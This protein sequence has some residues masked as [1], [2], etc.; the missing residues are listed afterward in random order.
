[1]AV[2]NPI[3]TINDI[4]R[5]RQIVAVLF[6]HG[7]GQIVNQIISADTPIAN[8]ISRFRKEDKI[9]EETGL[10]ESNITLA[11]RILYVLQELGPTFIK[12][13]QILST[14]ADL[15]PDEFIQE[16]KNLQDNVPS[17]SF[18]EARLIIE[19]ELSG[20]IE[21]IFESFDQRQIATASIGQVYTAVLRTGEDVVVKV[22]RPNV[23]FVIQRDIDLLYI[24]ARLAERQSEDLKLLDPVGIV[25][26]FE[27]AIQR[28]LD[29]NTE[30]R[31]ALRFKEAFKYHD[32]IE[33]PKV[34]KQYSAKKVLTM[35]KIKGVKITNAENIGCDKKILAKVALSAILHM[36]FENGFFHADP[37]PGNLF[38]LPGNKIGI[39]DLGMVGHLDN[40]MRDKL[41][42]LII[43]LNTRDTDGVAK[44]LYAIGKTEKRIDFDDF[45]KDVDE[46]LNKIL[47]LPL[48]EI[49]FSE[50]LNDLL[51]G[52]KKNRIKIPND[53][54]LMGKAIITIEG[55]GRV[56]DP[57]LNLEEE[58]AP[59]V[60]KLIQDRWTAKRLGLD[61]YKKSKEIYELSNTIPN[62]IVNILDDI[63][64]NNLKLNIENSKQ[65]EMLKIWEQIIGKLAAG[66]ITSALIISSTVFIVSTK[67][68]I[69]FR[70]LPLS[71]LLGIT[72]LI[73]AV[74]LGLNIIRN[75]KFKKPD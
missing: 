5:F 75:I 16:F 28:E 27:K 24:L 73:L 56:L 51:Q 18:E 74:I 52:A 39:L 41:A 72:Y 68:S 40:Q 62:Q 15:V 10:V 58:A 29:Y 63:Q 47:G 69:T 48:S 33:I 46:S 13:G 36:V 37:H 8:L 3:N 60:R 71:F 1:M 32:Q 50:V 30:F 34:Y 21:D 45:K 23:G 67:E 35:E 38:A 6:K 19:S 26:E 42:D 17:F 14:R 20:T 49:Q 31:N 9:D 25:K 64:N 43:S 65:A 22:Q 11:K 70:G 4:N 55:I 53:Y 59:F 57:S 66:F 61:L 54:T 44:S 12:L 7:F 2:F